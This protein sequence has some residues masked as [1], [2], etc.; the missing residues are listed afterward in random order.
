MGPT[1]SGN[2]RFTFSPQTIIAL[3]SSA[4]LVT[5]SIGAEERLT[6]SRAATIAVGYAVV[7]AV[8]GTV[9]ARRALSRLPFVSV[10]AFVLALTGVLGLQIRFPQ[11]A[12][13]QSTRTWVSGVG[14]DI[15]PCS[16]TA[17]CKTFAGAI[18][19]TAAQGEINVLDPGAFGAVTI[20][21][22]IT[23]SA[24]DVQAG[25]L[26]PGTNGI[27]INAGA[28]DH[29]VIRGLDIEGAGSGFNGIRFVAGGTLHVENTT[30]NGFTLNGIDVATSTMSDVIVKDT[31]IRRTGIGASIAAAVFVHPSAALARVSLDGV[32]LERSQVGLRAADRARVTIRNS[33]I[34]NNVGDGL[35]STSAT[36]PTT[37]FASGSSF[38]SQ[39]TA[40]GV[41]SDGASSQV[42]LS[43]NVV[44]RNNV[45]LQVV[46]NGKIFSFGN[47]AVHGNGTDGAPTST[48][49]LI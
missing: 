20:T 4:L 10:L 14:D 35:L 17:P 42:R 23:I 49:P 44:T 30:I 37:V 39:A 43:D 46:N 27:V 3:V 9:L 31:I 41:R 32:R 19:K 26:A 33:H 24:E 2:P 11:H 36:D 21:K 40:A 12:M 22:S 47:N 16:R 45:G 1:N 7:Y 48:V 29:V 34:A 18:S 38:V 5:I 8:I 28:G 6:G 15:N 13:A 25:V